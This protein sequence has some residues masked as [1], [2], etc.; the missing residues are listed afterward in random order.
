MAQSGHLSKSKLPLTAVLIALVG[1]VSFGGFALK[2]LLKLA[3]DAPPI[4]SLLSSNPGEVLLEDK[5]PSG[6][7]TADAP[8]SGLSLLSSVPSEVLLLGTDGSGQ[9]NQ[10][11]FAH[12]KVSLYGD[13]ASTIDQFGRGL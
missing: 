10:E 11:R 5:D 9:Q 8:P 6:Q 4:P 2:P 7:R 13:F 3:A 1:G 12:E